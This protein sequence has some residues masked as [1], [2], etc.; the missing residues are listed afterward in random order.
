MNSLYPSSA[1]Y[2]QDGPRVKRAR[3]NPPNSE[4]EDSTSATDAASAASGSFTGP[5][6]QLVQLPPPPQPP[7]A[8]P[9]GFGLDESNSPERLKKAMDNIMDLKVFLIT[10][11]AMFD[12]KDIIRKF[13]L[14]T[15]EEVSCVRWNN[16]FYITGT[17][18][19]R[20]LT[21][22]FAAF[23]RV[24]T[25]KKKFEEGVFSDLRNLKNNVDATLEKPKSEF[26]E[27]LYKHH[28]VRTK[29]KQKVFFWYSVRHER[30]FIDALERDLK[31]ES[32]KSLDGKTTTA[33]SEPALSFN[34]DPSRSLYDQI[35]GILGDMPTPL[36][37]IANATFTST[38]TQSWIPP[39]TGRRPQASQLEASQ[40]AQ[41]E[42]VLLRRT[43][44][45]NLTP[46]GNPLANYLYSQQQAPQ[47]LPSTLAST[48][49]NAQPPSGPP[50]AQYSGVNLDEGLEID[51][52]DKD[53]D[54]PLDF[55]RKED[56]KCGNTPTI[57]HFTFQDDMYENKY[58][59][60]PTPNPKPNS[61]PQQS[62]QVG[63]HV[64]SQNFAQS[65]HNPYGYPYLM[66]P[67]FVTQQSR[68]PQLQ[69]QSQ[70][71]LPLVENAPYSPLPNYY[72]YGPQY[73]G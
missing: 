25:N 63:G 43:T 2:G 23:G 4:V 22:R 15:D 5:N 70:P 48:Q 56:I 41:Q 40:L 16:V 52:F 13:H 14:P 3:V 35:G 57:N 39:S 44:K 32:S 50:P 46:A 11:P 28:C 24:I 53:S 7:A 65:Q 8:G 66:V 38:H 27:F 17:D 42:R 47:Q 59:A 67:Y 37:A 69:Q 55:L 29:K 31:K 49:S 30:L 19:V 60:Y 68:H 9:T 10:A 71:Q 18:I 34:Y 20:C 12:E 58:D 1:G 73:M 45:D 6:G 36:A 72:A 64:Q 62:G 26:L 51:I 61:A 21:Y 33:V 54:F